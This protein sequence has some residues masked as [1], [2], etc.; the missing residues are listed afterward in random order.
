MEAAL[1]PLPAI[2]RVPEWAERVA[3]LFV[4]DS[5]VNLAAAAPA[6]MATLL[7]APGSQW[8]CRVDRWVDAADTGRE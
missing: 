3:I 7:A 6:G 2:S 8:E 4:D 1:N 5:E